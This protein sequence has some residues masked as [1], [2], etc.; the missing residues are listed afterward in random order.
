MKLYSLYKNASLKAKM[1]IFA[2]LFCGVFIGGYYIYHQYKEYTHKHFE[3]DGFMYV[4][5]PSVSRYEGEVFLVENDSH[6]YTGHIHIPSYV[7]HDGYKYPVESIKKTA[8]SNNEEITGIYFDN[9]SP[10]EWLGDDTFKG[11]VNLKE[12]RLPQNFKKL[13]D[14]FSGCTSLE[15]LIIPKDT[16]EIDI[17]DCPGLKRFTVDPRNKLFISKNDCLY[18]IGEYNG[19]II[20]YNDTIMWKYPPA[21]EDTTFTFS[22]ASHIAYHAFVGAQKLKHIIIDD[23]CD[24]DWSFMD[25][26][27][28]KDIRIPRNAEMIPA[29]CF[30]GCK[31]LENVYIS[32]SSKLKTIGECAFEGCTQLVHIDGLGI[33]Q[34][35]SREK[36]YNFSYSAG[37]IDDKYI[38]TYP[39]FKLDSLKTIRANAFRDCISLEEIGFP[40]TVT[41]IDSCIFRGCSNLRRVNLPDTL[42]YIPNGMFRDCYRLCYVDMPLNLKK[43]G[44]SA[45][46]DC[47]SLTYI[48]LPPLT[49]ALAFA[50]FMG[51]S[52]LDEVYIPSRVAAISNMAFWDCKQLR[53]VYLNTREPIQ[54]SGTPFPE[55]SF[56]HR[57][58]RKLQK[59]CY[60]RESSLEAYQN[61]PYWKNNNFFVPNEY[62][63]DCHK[64]G[65]CGNLSSY[66]GYKKVLDKSDL[67]YYPDYEL[68]E[69]VKEQICDLLQEIIKEHNISLPSEELYTITLSCDRFGLYD[70]KFSENMTD[71][72]IASRLIE[73]LAQ[74]RY[75]EELYEKKEYR[76][77]IADY[78]LTFYFDKDKKCNFTD[79][80]YIP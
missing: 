50:C 57:L 36:S 20:E 3:V 1:K 72:S 68:R 24:L 19:T 56:L 4:L 75:I 2:V 48:S 54:V 78:M 25:C 35:A 9:D 58:F 38:D 31:S 43:I 27:S 44:I 69:N 39:A 77:Y 55:Y 59:I 7:E 76:K 23:S 79:Y 21:K 45:F 6:P 47:K 32:G 29:E 60:V 17:I 37:A 11:C 64:Y 80:D 10:L 73:Y 41:N 18:R 65:S 67:Y 63:W 62:D 8:F 30:K 12:V 46:R 61:D 71:K 14:I 74:L 70:I 22:D 28:L 66:Y 34:K 42:E 26:I 13:N 51:C 15:E 49:E 5:E 53:F 40:N 16:R 33:I 52:S